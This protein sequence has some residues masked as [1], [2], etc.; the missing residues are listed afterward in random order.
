MDSCAGD[1]SDGIEAL[2]SGSSVEIDADSTT[3]VVCCRDNRDRIFTNVDTI[4]RTM[5]E[6]IGESII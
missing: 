6:N 5:L 2:E 1:F 3:G 4:F